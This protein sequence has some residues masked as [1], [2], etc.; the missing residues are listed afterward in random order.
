MNWAYSMFHGKWHV[1]ALS[2]NSTKNK[3]YTKNP[4]SPT[5]I[6]CKHFSPGVKIDVIKISVRCYEMKWEENVQKSWQLWTLLKHVSYS[7]VDETIFKMH[8][9]QP[10]KTKDH[11]TINKLSDFY[12]LL[13][14]WFWYCTMNYRS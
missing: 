8:I 1:V 12:I 4:L 3:R 9:I 7:Y 13:L 6:L 5:I 11:D 10:R 2:Y 14:H